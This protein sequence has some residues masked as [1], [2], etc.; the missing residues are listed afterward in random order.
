MFSQGKRLHNYRGQLL[1]F[2]SFFLNM[3]KKIEKY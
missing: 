1:G 3:M 2:L